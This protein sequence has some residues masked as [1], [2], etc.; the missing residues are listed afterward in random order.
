M[1]GM[2]TKSGNR[3]RR[4]A[5]AVGA[6]SLLLVGSIVAL[7]YYGD[8]GL[9]GSTE[10]TVP[11]VKAPEQKAVADGELPGNSQSD[12]P[13]TEEGK[14]TAAAPEGPQ[15]APQAT[16]G[17]ASE[18]GIG[19]GSRKTATV[20]FPEGF[21]PEQFKLLE[22][23][24]GE[25]FEFTVRDKASPGE[26]VV[27]DEKGILIR[28]NQP[29]AAPIRVPLSRENLKQMSPAQR[30]ELRKAL[31]LQRQASENLKRLEVEKVSPVKP[32]SPP[33]PPQSSSSPDS[34]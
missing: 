14:E 27:F 4:M 15:T 30:R 10:S 17:K 20:V 9:A 13:V 7:V 34:N 2:V 19:T 6:F 16:T 21:D 5:A 29:G 28:P 22:K 12:S 32:P 24:L 23:E 25:D 18:K 3:R 31:E 33:P 26:R 8:T 1:G 11:E